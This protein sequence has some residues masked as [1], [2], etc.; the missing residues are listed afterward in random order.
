MAKYSALTKHLAGTA[1][2]TWTASFAKI[3]SIIGSRLPQSA[4][5][6]PAWWANQ[7]RAQSLA[8][9]RAGWR[10]SAVD[11]KR[12]TVT[13][14]KISPKAPVRAARKLTIAEAKAGLAA[15]FGIPVDAIEISIK[16]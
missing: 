14:T 1:G 9:E 10:K 6:Y 7:G 16:G 11:L 8:W 2:D 5:D 12:R 15:N 13:F 4:R 3:E